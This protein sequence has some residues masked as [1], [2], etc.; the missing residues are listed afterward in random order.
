MAQGYRI[1]L[2][3][4][5]ME[6][7]SLDQEGPLEKEMAT[8]SSI[9]TLKIPWTE[10]PGGLQSMGSQRVGH[11]WVTKQQNKW[12]YVNPNLP[13]HPHP[14]SPWSLWVSVPLIP[15]P[16]SILEGLLRTFPFMCKSF[17]M[18]FSITLSSFVPLFLTHVCLPH[19]AMDLRTK[20]ISIIFLNGEQLEHCLVLCF[21]IWKDEDTEREEVQLI[22]ALPHSPFSSLPLPTPHCEPFLCARGTPTCLQS[23]ALFSFSVGQTRLDG[24]QAQSPTVSLCIQSTSVFLVITSTFPG[25]RTAPLLCA[26]TAH[27]A[28]SSQ[29]FDISLIYLLSQ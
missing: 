25:F 2:L 26:L 20:T 8:H 3:L 27:S 6:V 16:C 18:C 19:W 14:H 23:P 21:V 29:H 9:L 15:R 12:I 22:P 4:Q 28:P 24:I 5:K 13:A 10:E 7:W 1:C 11:Y 17:H